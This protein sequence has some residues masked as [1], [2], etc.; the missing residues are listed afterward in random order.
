MAGHWINH[1]LP[2]LPR[3]LVCASID[4]AHSKAELDVGGPS[5][6]RLPRLSTAMGCID[7]CES[8]VNSSI[9]S[10]FFFLR[11]FMAAQK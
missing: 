8:G 3:S 10:F 7:P 6:Y 4:L 11:N 2:A 1:P 9:L 5:L